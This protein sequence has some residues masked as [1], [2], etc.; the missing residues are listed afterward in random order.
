LIID[1]V[2]QELD[3]LKKIRSTNNVQIQKIQEYRQSIITAAVTGKINVKQ[4]DA[5]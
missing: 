4:E 2:S 1:I 3:K 5:A